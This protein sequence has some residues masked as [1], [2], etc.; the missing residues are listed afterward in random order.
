MIL[1]LLL[2]PVLSYSMLTRQGI[3]RWGPVTLW[4]RYHPNG[5]YPTRL[6][7]SIDVQKQTSNPFSQPLENTRNHKPSDPS[8]RAS[9]CTF[10]MVQVAQVAAVVPRVAVSAPTCHVSHPPPSLPTL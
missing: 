6:R 5:G 1:S 9:L 3:F 2:M 8:G 10:W 7:R 4:T